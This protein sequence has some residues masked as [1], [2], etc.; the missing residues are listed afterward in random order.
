MDLS[1]TLVIY[2]A[3]RSDCGARTVGSEALGLT[4]GFPPS[5]SIVTGYMA[6]L[7][8]LF[9]RKW[10][11]SL[12]GLGVLQAR[13]AI[14]CDVI[15]G[16]GFFRIAVEIAGIVEQM[17]NTGRKLLLKL[18]IEVRQKYMRSKIDYTSI[19]KV[20]MAP[21]LVVWHEWPPEV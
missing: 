10:L 11:T 21:S 12:M 1:E 16:P 18:C 8:P 9:C 19:C 2:A 4:Y 13:S 14:F 17:D 20:K 3:Y 6:S 5:C 7:Q 15:A